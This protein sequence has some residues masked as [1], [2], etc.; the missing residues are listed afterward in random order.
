MSMKNSSDTFGNQTRNLPNCATLYNMLYIIILCVTYT[1]AYV[2]SPI[3][4][5]DVIFVLQ[6]R[7]TLLLPAFSPFLILLQFC[8]LFLSQ[9]RSFYVTSSF[10]FINSKK[11]IRYF[12]IFKCCNIRE[13]PSNK[14]AFKCFLRQNKV[15]RK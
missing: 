1:N 3:S 7:K 8:L 11:S 15:A 4:P 14:K 13:D 6:M 5:H 10:N 9:R 2:A 12:D